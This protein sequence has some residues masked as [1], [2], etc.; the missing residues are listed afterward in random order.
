MVPGVS[1]ETSTP[2]VTQSIKS[3][4]VY[5]IIGQK[6]II[7]NYGTV[8]VQQFTQYSQACTSVRPKPRGPDDM[9]ICGGLC[10]W[11]WFLFV[12]RLLSI[13]IDY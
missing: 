2:S 12:D 4:Q 7:C 10:L 13:S 5:S 8:H 1:G 11:L 6:H 9:I 3:N